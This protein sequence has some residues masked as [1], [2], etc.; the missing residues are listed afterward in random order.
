MIGGEA[1]RGFEFVN[2]EIGNDEVHGIDL[3]KVEMRHC[4]RDFDARRAEAGR[5]NTCF[6][7]VFV[8]NFIAEAA[9]RVLGVERELHN[10]IIKFSEFFFGDFER[11]DGAGDRHIPAG[12]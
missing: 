1:C 4:K 2:G 5:F 6:E 11:T 9:H 7:I 3:E 10:L 8:D 12:S